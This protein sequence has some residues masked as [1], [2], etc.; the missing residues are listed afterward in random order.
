M[1]ATQ[2]QQ[3]I[4]RLRRVGTYVLLVAFAIAL[5]GSVI[6]SF[7]L[8]WPRTL[9]YHPHPG[10]PL[11]VIVAS[12]L[13]LR[14]PTGHLL[15][16]VGTYGDELSSYLYFEYLRSLKSVDASR[17][18]VTATERSHGPEYRI[19]IELEDNVLTAVPYVSQ[20]QGSRF[21]ESYELV[22]PAKNRVVYY[23]E[24]TRL[25]TA[26]YNGP[27]RRKLEAIPPRKLTANVTRFL[28]FKAKTDRRIRER[29]EPVP[30]NLTREQARDLASDIIAVA[31]FYSLPLDFFLGV[32]AMENNFLD[33]RGD[34]KHTIW[35]RH[36]DPGDIVVRRR[37]GRVLVRNYSIGMWQ[38]TRETLRYA[39]ELYLKDKRDYS[40]LPERLRPPKDL[41]FSKV[42]S[43]VLTTYAGLLLRDLLDR[44]GG[45]VQKAVGAYNGGPS[46][47]N[48]Q[49]ADGVEQVASYAR[50]VLEQAAFINGRALAS[51]RLVISARRARPRV[52]APAERATSHPH[53]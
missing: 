23:R 50:R 4:G 13:E 39:H 38:I 16:R 8:L 33:V 5:S 53:R 48:L 29:I 9:S 31:K 6:L 44:F 42:D 35:K 25:F 2:A 52:N 46:N 14:S 36:P 27:V 24:Q 49:Y 45:D 10:L 19:Y 18:L 47:P 21:V 1:H 43:H 41:E 32:G 20:L 3:R 17:V 51:T 22:F 12:R 30:H 11:P 7:H 37:H 34:L 40:A 26:A 28:L 15:A